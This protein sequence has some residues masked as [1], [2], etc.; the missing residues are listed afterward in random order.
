MFSYSFVYYIYTFSYVLFYR[1]L[2][3]LMYNNKEH[4][5]VSI[6]ALYSSLSLS[7]HPPLYLG[8]KKNYS[9]SHE[10][11]SPIPSSICVLSS[12]LWAKCK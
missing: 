9:L 4:T 12:V 1:D 6:F 7:P 5:N 3:L 10:N 11:V 2:H 8:S